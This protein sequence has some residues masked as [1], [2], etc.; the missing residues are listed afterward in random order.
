MHLFKECCSCKGLVTFLALFACVNVRANESKYDRESSLLNGLAIDSQAV[1]LKPFQKGWLN[2]PAKYWEDTLI[3]PEVEC[4]FSSLYEG[5]SGVY[6]TAMQT[7]F[8]N[9]E[10]SVV[11]RN[12]STSFFLD[13]QDLHK[14]KETPGVEIINNGCSIPIDG[15]TCRNALLHNEPD[16]TIKCK[17]A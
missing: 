11:K 16:L 3:S 7:N 13:R 9:S 14:A 1:T 2:V 10:S 5:S 15:D 17:L 8:G 4:E 12:N 6:Y